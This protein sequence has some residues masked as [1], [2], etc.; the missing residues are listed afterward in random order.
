MTEAEVAQTLLRHAENF[1]PKA[2]PTCQRRFTSL[3]EYVRLTTPVGP[4]VS[5]DV[6]STRR[7]TAI[8]TLALANSPCGNTL[9]LT[10]DGLAIETRVRLLE[11]VRA[12]AARR[13]VSHTIVLSD[14]RVKMRALIRD[15]EPEP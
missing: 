1:F 4:C 14:L 2:C 5:Y 3:H 15:G 10:T 13:G 7:T 12:E 11:W 9:S 6:E 8:G